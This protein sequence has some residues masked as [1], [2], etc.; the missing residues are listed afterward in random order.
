VSESK[1]SP[2]ILLTGV[3]DILGERVALLKLEF[4]AKPPQTPTERYLIL[5]EGQRD[6]DVE[7]L[8]VDVHAGIVTLACDGGLTTL[9]LER[10]RP[11]L[12]E[13]WPTGT[14]TSTPSRIIRQ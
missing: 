7:V 14:A 10:D 11:K 6:G 13:T 3:T 12:P 4:P 1:P 9:S 8:R 5:A 2:R